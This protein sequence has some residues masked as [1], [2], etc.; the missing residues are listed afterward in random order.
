MTLSITQR[1]RARR[2]YLLVTS[3]TLRA[4]RNRH[5][6]PRGG[7]PAATCRLARLPPAAMAAAAAV[8]AAGATAPSRGTPAAASALVEYGGAHRRPP[9]ARLPA[10]VVAAVAAATAEAA[11]PPPGGMATDEQS[12][13]TPRVATNTPTIGRRCRR[14][15]SI[16]QTD[17]ESHQMMRFWYTASLVLLGLLCSF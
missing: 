8:T 10:V 4:T 17:R 5:R 12:M 1:E 11:A 9:A 7:A 16:L 13:P 3:A 2:T 14:L 15:V 6:R